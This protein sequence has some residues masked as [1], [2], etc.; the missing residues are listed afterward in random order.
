MTVRASAKGVTFLY[1]FKGDCDRTVASYVIKRSLFQTFD[2][3]VM[4][5]FHII[6]KPLLMHHSCSDVFCQMCANQKKIIVLN[7]KKI[8]KI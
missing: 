8:N 6:N 3:L 1:I 7:Y 4:H 5:Y 2:S